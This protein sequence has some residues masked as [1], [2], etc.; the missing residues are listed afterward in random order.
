MGRV[1]LRLY[2]ILARASGSRE[3]EVE[4]S[5][6][7]TVRCLLERASRL[8]P[9]LARAL[10]VLGWD[11]VV[12]VNGRSRRL[13]DP[14]PRE[15]VVNVL[16]PASGGG[17]VILAGILGPGEEVDLDDIV[18][19]LSLPGVG[20]V[21]LFVGVVRSPNRGEEVEY[22]DYDYDPEMTPEWLE[23]LARE[24]VEKK[25]LAGVALY[26]Y[27]GRRRPGERTMI[28]AVAAQVR[29]EAFEALR[30]IVDRVKREAP[31]WKAEKRGGRIY[32]HVGE[33]E[34]PEDLL[35][36]PRGRGS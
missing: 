26:H 10:D 35:R 31:I 29:E 20:A 30:E 4:S 23:R 27:V 36:E 17:P 33:R 25:G 5:G 9:G 6:C 28:A 12:I 21:A 16:P 11:V 32:Y 22:L 13:E 24:E 1:R 34:I 18:S 2:G 19:R 3:V 14:A 15:G 7:D 8:A